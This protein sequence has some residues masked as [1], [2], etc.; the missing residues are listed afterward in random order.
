MTSLLRSLSTVLVVAGVSG[1]LLMQDKDRTF[2]DAAASPRLP[3]ITALS[4]KGKTEVRPLVES[5][6]VALETS[7]R[8]P[9]ADIDQAKLA[10]QS[11]ATSQFV[12]ARRRLMSAV[13]NEIERYFDLFMY[14]SKSTRGPL[15]QHMFV[16]ALMGIRSVSPPLDD[17]TSKSCREPLSQS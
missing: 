16:F 5:D 12:L 13:P 1:C 7:A 11:E 10:S 2:M 8:G 17:L 4:N 14:V 3:A 9:V 15:G 6:G